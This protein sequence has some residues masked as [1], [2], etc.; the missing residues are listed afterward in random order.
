[1]KSAVDVSDLGLLNANG[2]PYLS[3]YLPVEGADVH[4]RQLRAELAADGAPESALALVD[5]LVAGVDTGEGTLAVIAGERSVYAVSY[6]RDSFIYGRGQWAGAADLVPLIKE[7][8]ERVGDKNEVAEHTVDLLEQFKAGPAAD[9]IRATVAAMS[10]AEVD[11][12]L[13]RDDRDERREVP[14]EDAAVVD[15]LVRDAIA[16]GASVYVIP[17]SGPVT[18]GVGAL[19]R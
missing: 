3:V 4:W 17:A 18:E 16:I 10:R 19:L 1:M 15:A 7:R 5:P 2:G 8:Q 13:V 12:L 9:G 6:L 14:R 11:V